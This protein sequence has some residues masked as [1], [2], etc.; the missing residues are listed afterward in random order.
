MTE[1]PVIEIEYCSQCQ[2]LLR[3]A[4]LAQE[5]LSTFNTDIGE[6]RLKPGGYLHH[7]AEWRRDLGKEKEWRFSST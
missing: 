7:Q 2:W 4:W 3:S 5:L 1:K 6:A